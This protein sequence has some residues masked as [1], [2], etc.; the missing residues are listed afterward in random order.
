MDVLILDSTVIRAHP[1]A[2]GAK[3]S[4]RVGR[5][6]GRRT[7]TEPRGGGT[8][9]HGSFNGIGQSVALRLTPGQAEALLANHQPEVVIVDKGYDSNKL[10]E[11]IAVRD[12]EAVIPPKWNRVGPREY[13]RHTDKERNVCERF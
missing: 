1:S 9:I 4:E 12:A 5:S 11:E 10:V 2:A 6:S 3:K 8:K 7:G 13:D